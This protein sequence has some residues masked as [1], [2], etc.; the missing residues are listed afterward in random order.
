MFAASFGGAAGQTP[1]RGKQVSTVSELL[2]LAADPKTVFDVVQV[3]EFLG[4]LPAAER[5]SVD[6]QL[7]G[8]PHEELL[9][10]VLVRV[11]RTRDEGAAELIASR[12]SA[13]KP[14]TR[15]R[16]IH[17]AAIA[18]GPFQ[19]IPRALLRDAIA[20][21]ASII[22]S[23]DLGPDS[24]GRAA[25]VLAKTGNPA[26]VQMV[27]SAARLQPRSWGV[28][29]ALAYG[30]AMN[31]SLVAVAEDIYQDTSA[32]LPLRV[33][34]ATALEPFDAKAGAY[35][36]GQIQSYLTQFGGQDALV[37]AGCRQSQCRWGEQ[38]RPGCDPVC[39]LQE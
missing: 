2:S 35:A 31:P 36:V 16:A 4:K 30:E 23:G 24:L 29:M 10:V 8:L 17:I 6:H 1:N 19:T 27:Q 7:I 20:G 12:I 21:G 33:A 18:R 3:S 11:L 28:W 34:A 14:T 25:L 38:P 5:R 32:A 37:A 9:S 13:W 26:N 15:L 22:G 39:Q